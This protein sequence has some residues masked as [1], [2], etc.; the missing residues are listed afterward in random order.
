MKHAKAALIFL[1]LGYLNLGAVIITGDGL[2][3]G[4]GNTLSSDSGVV[5]SNNTMN[6]S[7]ADGNLIVGRYNT[8]DYETEDSLIVGYGNSIGEEESRI[9]LLGYANTGGGHAAIAMGGLNSV[10]G[11]YAVAIGYS[12]MIN[13][14]R[15]YGIGTGLIS[16]KQE[17]VYLGRYN[18]TTIIP[19]EETRILVVGNGNG[20]VSDPAERSNALIVYENGD[21]SVQQDVYARNVILDEPAGDISMG[22]FGEN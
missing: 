10:G 20:V 5:G 15:A 17:V 19:D 4:S 16:D 12:N 13:R 22:Q 14:L 18:D 3:I 6:G 2:N 8:I 1:L 11:Y 21:L 7:Q 9:I